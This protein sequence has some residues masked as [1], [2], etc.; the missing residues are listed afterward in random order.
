[1]CIFYRRIV[2][3]VATKPRNGERSGA[4]RQCVNKQES[5]QHDRV[6]HWQGTGATAQQI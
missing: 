2:E 5:E 1:M 3:N 4:R 6:S